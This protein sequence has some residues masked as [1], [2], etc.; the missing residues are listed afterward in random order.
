L[1]VFHGDRDHTVQHSNAAQIVEQA[2]QAHAAHGV[3]LTQR[4]QTRKGVATGGRSYSRAVYADREGR[5]TIE[6]WTLH[7]A[8]HAWS[9][10]H[11]SGSYTDA[12]GPDA[13]AEMVRF[14]LATRPGVRS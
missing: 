8:G 10:G 13:S 11:A 1:I 7:G 12:A 4:S 3:D 14:F 5:P 6:A 2:L 9:G